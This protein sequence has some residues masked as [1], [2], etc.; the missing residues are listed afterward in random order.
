MLVLLKHIHINSST[1]R[2]RSFFHPNAYSIVEV[3]SNGPIKKREEREKD[4][5]GKREEQIINEKYL[6]EEARIQLMEIIANLNLSQGK[7]RKPCMA[8]MYPIISV[9]SNQPVHQPIH[10]TVLETSSMTLTPK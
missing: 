1:Y 10:P 4:K 6:Y 3:E 5:T 2:L 7:S 9:L 8:K